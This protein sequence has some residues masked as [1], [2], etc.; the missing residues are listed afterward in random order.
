MTPTGISN[1]V[2]TE[3]SFNYFGNALF[4]I[5]TISRRMPNVPMYTNN[6]KYT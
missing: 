2:I 3:N 4:L 1:A 5:E 6:D